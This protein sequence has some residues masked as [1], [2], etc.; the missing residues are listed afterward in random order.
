MAGPCSCRRTPRGR[1]PGRR[2]WPRWCWPRGRSRRGG[3]AGRPTARGAVEPDAAAGLAQ[4]QRRQVA[5]GGAEAGGPED[6]RRPP[7]TGRRSHATPSGVIRSN[8]GSRSRTPRSRASRTTGSR[9][10]GDADDAAAAAAPARTA[11]ARPGRRRARPRV[12]VERSVAPDRR[13]AGDPGRLATARDLAEQLHRRA[14]PPTTTTRWPANSPG[15]AVVGGVQLPA[16][17]RLLARVVR[18]E[19]AGPGAG[20]VDHG[21][22]RPVPRRSRRRNRPSRPARTAVTRPGGAPAARTALVVGEVGG[23]DLGGRRLAVAGGEGHAGQVVQPWDGAARSDGQRCCHAPPGPSP[24]S[25]TTKP[26]AGRTPAGPAPT[27]PTGRPAPPRSPPRRAAAR[28]RKRLDDRRSSEGSRTGAR[29]CASLA[30]ACRLPCGRARTVARGG[31]ERRR[32]PNWTTEVPHGRADHPGGGVVSGASSAL[33]IRWR[34]SAVLPYEDPRSAIAGTA[35]RTA[36]PGRLGRAAGLHRTGGRSPSPGRSEALT[37]AAGSGSPTPPSSRAPT[38]ERR[39]RDS[40]AGCARAGGRTA[41]PGRAD[42]GGRR[43]PG[44]QCPDRRASH[45][46]ATGSP[47]QPGAVMPDATAAPTVALVHGAFADS[48]GWTGVIHRLRAAGVAAVADLQPAARHL[49]GRRLRRQ[50]PRPDPRAGARRRPLLRRGDHHQRRARRRAT[51][52]A[53]STWPRSPRTRARS[54]SR[55]RTAPP[56]AC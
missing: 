43:A 47:E 4:V 52:S 34:A 25:R 46:V 54:C 7:R 1:R 23:H 29:P 53:W 37:R 49:R 31:A 8:I 41:P 11:L 3:A 45:E 44:W 20:R 42:R 50:R 30:A 27:P 2:G 48:S 26:V 56:T 12:L 14:P 6:R 35:R 13:P 33:G 19:R 15:P 40:D 36:P 24:A 51:S 5:E 22:C 10:A 9:Q 18:H 17:E 16:G 39:G 28:R 55:W 38:T 32:P 21:P